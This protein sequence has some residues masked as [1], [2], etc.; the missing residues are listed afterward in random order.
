MKNYFGLQEQLTDKQWL[1]RLGIWQS[2]YFLRNEWSGLFL[3]GKELVVFITNDKVWA[4]KWKLEFWKPHVMYL[5]TTWLLSNT[6]RLLMGLIMIF[7][8][9][10]SLIFH[11]KIC[12]Q[13]KIC[14]SRWINIFFFKW[15]NHALVKDPFY[16]WDRPVDFNV[17]E[18][19]KKSL[20]WFHITFRNI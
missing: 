8:N 2:I 7:M 19:E 13:V 10:V 1:F 3:Q 9:V 5:E 15:S 20:L 4:F 12:Q 6:Y 17:T 11:N 14:V 16:E 18:C